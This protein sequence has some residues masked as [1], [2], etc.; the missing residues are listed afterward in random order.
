MNDKSRLAATLACTLAGAAAPGFAQTTGSGLTLQGFLDASVRSTHN[1]LGTL[2]S[3]SSGNNTTSRIIFR[4]TEDLGDGLYA[5]FWLE[6]TLMADTGAAGGVNVAPANQFFDRIS[7]LKIGSRN[8]GEFRLG[9][10]W[11]P[12][13]IGWAYSD[14]F[15]AVGVGSS[16]NF[17]SAGGGP[18][19]GSS[20]VL[21]RA[22]G[23]VVSPSTI[24][25]TSNAVQYLT[26]NGLGGAFA[27]LMF[28]PGEAANANGSFKYSSGRAGWKGSAFE[29][30]A[31]Y[32]STRIDAQQSNIKQTG[33]YTGYDAGIVRV[34]AS[35]TESKFLSSKQLNYILGLNVPIGLHLIRAS[36]NR[37]DQRGTD[38]AGASIDANDANMYCVGYQYN[39]SKRTALYTQV[40]KITNKG[41]ARF[42][43]PGGPAGTIGVGTSS[44][45]YEAG[46]RTAF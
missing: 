31:Y 16:A 45:G 24:S 18:G 19:S 43:V 42:Q 25:R 27:H 7:T 41:T 30:S 15:V 44:T 21:A 11:N 28:A 38:A 36:Y 12:V 32:S 13:F 17:F 34:A 22:F 40:A 35:V 8:W 37:A 29:L 46:L 5:G 6:S 14:P 39:L 20:T 10:E 33:I 9:R 4:G 26:P 3:L 2:Q 23:T 1:S